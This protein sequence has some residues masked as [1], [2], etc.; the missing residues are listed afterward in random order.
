MGAR[1]GRFAVPLG[2]AAAIVIFMT[3]LAEAPASSA[4]EPKIGQSARVA[5]A[6]DEVIGIYPITPENE[7]GL[8]T[9]SPS[10]LRKEDRFGPPP[11]IH[12]SYFAKPR[13]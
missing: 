9:R 13:I 10:A 12:S 2:C 5:Y 1:E 7:Y 11:M 6:L 8:A 3:I 4:L